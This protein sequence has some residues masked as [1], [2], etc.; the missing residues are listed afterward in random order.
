[1]PSYPIP[2]KQVPAVAVSVFTGC[3]RSFHRDASLAIS[4]LQ[5]TPE[6]RGLENIPHSGPYLITT[7]HY[8]A[9]GFGAWWITLAIS[10]MTPNEVHW[11]MTG[12]WLF[13]GKFYETPVRILTTWLFQRIALIYGFTNM[14]PIPPYSN[15]TEGRARAVRGILSFARHT[16]NP[17]I[18]IAPEGTDHPNG[19]LGMPPAGLGRFI[20][21]LAPYCQAILPVGVF[22]E[23]SRLCVQ[24]G[25]T[26]PLEI[27]NG[28]SPEQV[29]THVSQAVMLVI[30]SQLPAHLRGTFG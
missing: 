7:N 15:D 19:V 25:A 26:Y 30:A 20:A 4:T 3:P 5:T 23:A 16:P 29:D 12:A 27:P 24:F 17:V 14:P 13:P 22:E 8:T 9:P 21:R 18:G 1:M 11:I 10:S 6:F 2:W 28:L